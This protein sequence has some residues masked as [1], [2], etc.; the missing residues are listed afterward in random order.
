M[1][2]SGLQVVGGVSGFGFEAGWQV[3]TC[4][5]QCAPLVVGRH[6]QGQNHVAAVFVNFRSSHELGEP[7]IKEDG[8]VEVR[9]CT[10]PTDGSQSLQ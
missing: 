7:I 5:H 6:A 8:G 1:D 9:R 2:A 10:I 4:D 3:C